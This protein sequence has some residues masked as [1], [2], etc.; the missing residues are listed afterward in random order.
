MKK[1]PIE[2]KMIKKLISW[3]YIKLV[4]VPTLEEGPLY[5]IIPG[6]M[7]DFQEGPFPRVPPLSHEEIKR[8]NILQARKER[9]WISD[10]RL[11]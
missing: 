11:H 6:D 10:D 2:E 3:L 1:S 4:V 8:Q 7:D 9:K 5:R